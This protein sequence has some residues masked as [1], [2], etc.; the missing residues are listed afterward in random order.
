[1]PPRPTRSR[2]VVITGAGRNFVGGAD[3]REF[4]APMAEPTLP[5]I[6]DRIEASDKPIVAAINGAALGGGLEFA[7]GCHHRIAAPEAK[8]GLPEVKLGIVPG[9]GGTQRLPRLAGPAAAVELIASGRIVTAAE[10][11]SLGIV[12]R[13]VSGDLIAAAIAMARDLAGQPPRRTGDLAVPA[14]D[15]DTFEQAAAKALSRMRGQ[16]ASERGRPPRA[17]RRPNALAE[18]LAD[19]RATFLRL[20][21]SDRGQGAA[22]RLLRRARRGQG[23]RARRRRA[24]TGD[25]DRRGRNRPDGLRHRG[26]GTRRRLSRHRRRADR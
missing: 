23:G 1:M 16:Q 22:P 2:A 25:D 15:A 21:D 5:Q 10:A 19:E 11:L 8:L 17:Q 3:I 6:I 4:G 9:A 26:R 18:G 12:D 24:E 7:L 20:R 14:V 13:V